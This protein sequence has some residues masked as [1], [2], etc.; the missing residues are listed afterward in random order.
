M[1]I[2]IVDRGSRIGSWLIGLGSIFG[3]WIWCLFLLEEV[4]LWSDGDGAIGEAVDWSDDEHEDC[5]EPG[6]I[7][8]RA[9]L[10]FICLV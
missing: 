3:N 1:D 4:D 7:F 10:H 2:G 9:V 5:V 6:V 8:H